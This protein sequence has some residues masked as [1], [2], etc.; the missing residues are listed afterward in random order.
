M[1]QIR[2]SMEERLAFVQGFFDELVLLVVEL[3]DGFLQVADAAVHEF[4][5]FGGGA[6]E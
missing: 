4:G 1:T 3:E 2:R 6:C 5:R